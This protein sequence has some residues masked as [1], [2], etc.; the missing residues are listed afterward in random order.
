MG[1]QMLKIEVHP[2]VYDELNNSRTQYDEKASNLGVD[3]LME[4]NNAIER[5]RES[6]ET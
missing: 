4:V 2:K 3:F 5:I 1:M 6:L